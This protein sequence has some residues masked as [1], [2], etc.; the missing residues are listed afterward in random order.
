MS[1]TNIVY[2]LQISDSLSYEADFI[3]IYFFTILTSIVFEIY[4]NILVVTSD[5]LFINCSY[6]LMLIAPEGIVVSAARQL[7]GK[8]NTM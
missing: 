3:L 2:L 5:Y 4:V 7:S 6:S 8:G 1:S